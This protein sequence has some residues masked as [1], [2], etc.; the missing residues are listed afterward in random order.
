MKN[1]AALMGF[2]T[3]FD[4]MPMESGK[5]HVDITDE[6]IHREQKERKEGYKNVLL[7]KGVKEFNIDG[8]TILAINEKNAIRKSLL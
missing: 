2:A 8:R 3:G 4:G 6:T 1:L 5:V 7:S